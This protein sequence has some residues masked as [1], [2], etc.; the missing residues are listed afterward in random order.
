[1]AKT[2][3]ELHADKDR[4]Y[5]AVEQMRVA[6]NEGHHSQAVR[7]ALVACD[8]VDGMMQFE[9]RFEN[10]LDPVSVES[11]DYVLRYAPLLLDH[12][13]LAKIDALFKSQKRIVKNTSVSLAENLA[14]AQAVIWDA[15]RLWNHLERQ[16]ETLQ[17]EMRAQLGGDQ[18]RWR[19]IIEQW[20]SIGLVRRIPEST[21][22]RIRFTTR[23][24]SIV[25]AKCSS[26][27]VI[28]CAAL[29]R[30]L[31]QNKCP[32]CNV[33]NYFVLLEREHAQV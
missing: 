13:S 33:S 1:M 10:V 31:E 9:H 7:V 25:K 26:C 11:I 15:H 21:S 19:W 23:I 18:S 32:K 16:E 20:E 28:A 12:Q 4:Y 24:A 29:G 8:Y 3:A 2:K 6:H 30:F 14:T 27:G 22:Y 17:D 5:S